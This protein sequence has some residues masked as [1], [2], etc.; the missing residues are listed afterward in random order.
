M[1]FS[2]EIAKGLKSQGWQVTDVV[3]NEAG[4]FVK[5][6]EHTSGQTVVMFQT[7]TADLAARRA[8]VE[9][10]IERNRGADLADPWPKR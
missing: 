7:D 4:R 3:V 6:L 5:R 8:T 10:I 2:A 1:D 9:Q